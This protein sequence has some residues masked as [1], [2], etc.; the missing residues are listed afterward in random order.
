M[1]VASHLKGMSTAVLRFASQATSQLYSLRT[2]QPQ[3]DLASKCDE[4]LGLMRVCD[5]LNSRNLP[6]QV[7]MLHPLQKDVKSTL[8]CRCMWRFVV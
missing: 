4:L 2:T 6:G 1:L 3:R 5:N 7:A 8:Y